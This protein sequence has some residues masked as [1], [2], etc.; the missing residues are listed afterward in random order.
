MGSAPRRSVQ[1]GL[2]G[3]HACRPQ[4]VA[5]L[6]EDRLTG[7]QRLFG[8]VQF[9]LIAE[10]DAE[11]AERPCLGGP[12]ADGTERGQRGVQML[13]WRLPTP[14]GAGTIRRCSC[15]CGLSSGGRRSPRRPPARPTGHRRP[16][17]AVPRGGKR[18]R[19]SRN[20][21]HA[22]PVL[23]F[24]EDGQ[25]I[26]EHRDRGAVSPSL[27]CTMASCRMAR[28]SHRRSPSCRA[29]WS[30]SVNRGMACSLRCWSR[31]TS[32]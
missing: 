11:F 16:R 1:D 14:A 26:G 22:S 15:G 21:G 8:A 29:T 2:A 20:N 32:A 7:V 17:P 10:Q 27:R 3:Q 30:P 13:S 24:A 19:G 9:T 12:V 4:R 28:A 25:A 5:Q 18:R 6:T 31:K 23:Q